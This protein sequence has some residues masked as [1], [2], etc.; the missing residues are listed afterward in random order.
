VR[1]NAVMGL[2]REKPETQF[3]SN[4]SDAHQPRNAPAPIIAAAKPAT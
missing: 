3:D 4:G 1:H 2:V